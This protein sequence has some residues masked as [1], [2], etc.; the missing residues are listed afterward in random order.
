MN[1][2]CRYIRGA[3]CCDKLK[4]SHIKTTSICD[5]FNRFITF[6]QNDIRNSFVGHNIPAP[7]VCGIVVWSNANTIRF[8]VEISSGRTTAALANIY[9]IHAVLSNIHGVIHPVV[10]IYEAHLVS[11]GVHL[12]I[13]FFNIHTVVAIGPSRVPGGRRV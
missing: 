2:F 4:T 11:I 13:K 12:I 8:K 9:R 3:S 1:I 7:C 6:R 10:R 5:E